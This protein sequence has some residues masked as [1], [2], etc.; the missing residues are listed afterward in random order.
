MWTE[1]K[2]G[3]RTKDLSVHSFVPSQPYRPRLAVLSE[4]STTEDAQ[5]EDAEKS[6]RNSLTVQR[7][8]RLAHGPG[9]VPTR[10][11]SA[12]HAP[13]VHAYACST[14]PPTPVLRSAAQVLS[15]LH[16]CIHAFIHVCMSH[17]RRNGVTLCL[18][19]S[20]V[21]FIEENHFWSC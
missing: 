13:P 8:T 9:A 5:A 12:A 4:R 21:G 19:W 7:S 16:S 3:N 2:E 18:F 6:C 1:G 17:C 15:L 20:E 11:S 10:C 14:T